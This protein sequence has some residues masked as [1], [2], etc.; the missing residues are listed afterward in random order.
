MVP[1]T[2]MVQATKLSGTSLKPLQLHVYSIDQHPL[3][4]L[5][6]PVDKILSQ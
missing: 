3:Y 6:V 4:D 5:Q 2:S 1:T